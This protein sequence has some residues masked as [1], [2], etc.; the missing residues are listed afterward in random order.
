[1][2]L[3]DGPDHRSDSRSIAIVRAPSVAV[4]LS[5]VSFETEKVGHVKC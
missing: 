3:I 5:N 4:E 2:L 1:M